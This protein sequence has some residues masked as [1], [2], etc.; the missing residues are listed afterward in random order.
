M[1]GIGWPNPGITRVAAE[2]DFI[3]KQMPVTDGYQGWRH[4]QQL[5][6]EGGLQ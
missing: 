1:P 6:Q 4:K 5:I 3:S 2:E